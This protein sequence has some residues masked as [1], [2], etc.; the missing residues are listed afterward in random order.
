MAY[1]WAFWFTMGVG[2]LVAQLGP[3]FRLRL[4]GNV[5]ALPVGVLVLARATPILPP[6]NAALPC[7]SQFCEVAPLFVTLQTWFKGK[8]WRG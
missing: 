1:L 3:Y 6:V 8:S 4:A 2:Q 7:S 5:P